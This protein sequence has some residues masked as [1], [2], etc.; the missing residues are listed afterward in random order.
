MIIESVL[1]SLNNLAK[2]KYYKILRGCNKEITIKCS[3][4][5]S[6]CPT[7]ATAMSKPTMDALAWLGQVSRVMTTSDIWVALLAQTVPSSNTVKV[8][9]SV[10]L[11][12][13]RG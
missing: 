2:K 7:D 12:P 6:K 4:G 10:E 13:I 11:D 8:R 5:G 1:L 9:E 3:K